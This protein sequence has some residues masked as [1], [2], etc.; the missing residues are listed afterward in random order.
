MNRLLVAALSLSLLVAPCAA[1]RMSTVDPDVPP[2]AQ[3]VGQWTP[4]SAQMGGKDF[5]VAG[6]NG[7]TLA[8]TERTYA[9]GNDRGSYTITYT[10]TPARMDIHGEQGPNAG[11]TIPALYLLSGN[12]LTVSYQLGPG[13][14]PKD[15]DSPAGSQILVVHYQRTR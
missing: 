3:L 14:R 6:F 10:G 11:K 7:A 8:M 13:V 5:P 4:T 1:R 12:A 2:G 9:F 15:F